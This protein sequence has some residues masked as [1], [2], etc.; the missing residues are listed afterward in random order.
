MTVIPKNII[1]AKPIKNQ[2]SKIIICC[3]LLICGAISAQQIPVST[4]FVENPFAFNPAVAGSDNGF[5]LRTDHRIQWMGFG[6]GPFT[7]MVSG[8]G[9][10]RSRP[11]GYG[12]NLTVDKTGL[13]S[14]LKA[15]AGYAYNIFITSDVR[16]SFGLNLGFIQYSVDGTQ[17]EHMTD[18]N[19]PKAPETMMSSFN[20]DAGAGLYVYHYDWYFGLSA[21]QL[22]SNNVKFSKDAPKDPENKLKT[23]F[24]GYGGYK[25][26]SNKLVIEPAILARMVSSLPMQ[27]DINAR[28]M[29]NTQIWGGISA[30]NTLD[31]FND[32]SL[33]FGYIHERRIS[34]SIAYDFIFADIRSYTPGTIEIVLGYNFDD[35]KKGR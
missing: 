35:L 5:K 13:I 9:P 3:W 20:P 15:N 34:I 12:V 16:A 27:F 24:F 22:F 8:Y 2:K 21:Q 33:I 31:S 30:R 23:H 19:D 4:I 18:P 28:V 17:F 26:Y 1:S 6:D 14:M 10:H 25:F 32:L 11:M 29:Y 7:N